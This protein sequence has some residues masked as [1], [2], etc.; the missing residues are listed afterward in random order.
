MSFVHTKNFKYLKNMLIGVGASV[1]MITNRDANSGGTG[2]AVQAP[3]G[4][5]YILTNAH[6]CIGVE[7]PLIITF[8][9]NRQVPLRIVEVSKKTDLCLIEAVGNLPALKLS[10]SL[11]IGQNIAIVGHPALMD[12][13]LSRGDLIQRMDLVLPVPFEFCEIGD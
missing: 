5:S 12:L 9:D 13:T 8:K 1:V 11:E 7:R 4:K 3:S 10:D 2:F 6:V